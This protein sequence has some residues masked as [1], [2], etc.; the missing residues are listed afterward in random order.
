MTWQVM[1][2]N[3]LCH[4]DTVHPQPKNLFVENVIN[5]SWNPPCHPMLCLH[6]LNLLRGW[7]AYLAADLQVVKCTSLIKLIMVIILLLMRLY[8][9][10][11][12]SQGICVFQVP[13]C[14]F[15]KFIGAMSSVPKKLQKN[16]VVFNPWRYPSHTTVNVGHS[17]IVG[18]PRQYVCRGCHSMKQVKYMCVCCERVV[19]KNMCISFNEDE[20]NFNQYIV[21]KCIG[22]V[23]ISEGP[24]YILWIVTHHCWQ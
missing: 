13:W 8:K 20:Y 10:N 11:R 16:F 4:M 7:D 21:Y 9:E 15:R 3:K 1:M 22:H 19:N 18:M 5:F 12:R 6:Q 14:S 24:H 17:T 2:W 23:N